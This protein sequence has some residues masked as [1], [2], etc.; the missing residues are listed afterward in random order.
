L[1]ALSSLKIKRGLI[2]FRASTSLEGEE[3]FSLPYWVPTLEEGLALGVLSV[4][5]HLGQKSRSGAH[6]LGE[7]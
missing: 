4:S 5:R 7:A 1:L 3:D 6:A 2:S